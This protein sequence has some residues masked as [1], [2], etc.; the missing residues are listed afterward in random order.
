MAVL[1][2]FCIIS[3][4]AVVGAIRSGGQLVGFNS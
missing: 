1:H 3:F 4:Y 2:V